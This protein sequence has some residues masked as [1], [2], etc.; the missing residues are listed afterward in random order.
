MRTCI[1]FPHMRKSYVIP[2]LLDFLVQFSFVFQEE[3]GFLWMFPP[4]SLP[5]G[6]MEIRELVRTGEISGRSAASCQGRR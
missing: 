2:I 6:R 5:G 3:R 4:G 1:R